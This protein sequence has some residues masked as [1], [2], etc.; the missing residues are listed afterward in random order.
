M[1]ETKSTVESHLKGNNVSVTK[2]YKFDYYKGNF[3]EWNPR[4]I[5]IC[6]YTG[7]IALKHQNCAFNYSIFLSLFLSI[8]QFIASGSGSYFQLW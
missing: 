6:F 2:T 7:M 1:F 8:C 5:F 3:P 4:V